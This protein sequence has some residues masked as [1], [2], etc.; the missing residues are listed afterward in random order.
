M[1]PRS[2]RAVRDLLRRFPPQKLTCGSAMKLRLI[3]SPRATAANSTSTADCK[4]AVETGLFDSVRSARTM[5]RGIAK[6]FRCDAAKHHTGFEH[7]SYCRS[8]RSVNVLERGLAIDDRKLSANQYAKPNVV[9]IE[10]F[11]VSRQKFQ[12]GVRIG[13]GS[14][15]EYAPP[16]TVIG[17][18]HVTCL[19]GNSRFSDFP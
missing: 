7:H 1:R 14:R 10:S 17:G 6:Q 19:I 9:V 3:C 18:A 11:V 4:P 2:N 5:I 16:R 8:F 13:H 15:N 12:I